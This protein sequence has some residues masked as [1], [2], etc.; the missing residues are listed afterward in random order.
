VF[1]A[2]AQAWMKVAESA[3]GPSR[4]KAAEKAL[5]VCGQ[6]LELD[7]SY[8]R[9]HSTMGRAHCEL[10]HYNESVT[11]HRKAVEVAN[12]YLSETNSALVH[13]EFADTLRRIAEAL[14]DKAP[15]KSAEF[16]KEA[17][18]ECEGYLAKDPNGP[19]ASECREIAA[20]AR[21]AAGSAENPTARQ[22][23][24]E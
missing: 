2:E 23:G 14:K 17:I 4:K 11:S 16:W 7:E 6:A 22:A 8:C 20:C 3:E 24:S 18:F 9:A 5:E 13:F 10:K 12:R 21:T 1:G 19:R 15:E